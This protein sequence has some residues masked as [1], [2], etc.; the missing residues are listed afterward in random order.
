MGYD[1]NGNQVTRSK[2]WR[3]PDTMTEAQAKKE[4]TKQAMLFE[5]E[6]SQGMQDASIK[7]QKFVY[8]C[9]QLMHFQYI[10]L[11]TIL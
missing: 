3:P 11:M 5:N 9:R 2:T 8:L 1:V 7:F 6:C 4:A 10:S